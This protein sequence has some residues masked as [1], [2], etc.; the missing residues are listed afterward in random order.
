MPS[1]E[2][3]I[4]RDDIDAVIIGSPHTAHLPQT[5]AAAAAGKHV[6]VEKPMAVSV[7]ECDRM[8]EACRGGRRQARRQQGPALPDRAQAAKELID[9][10]VIGDVRMI[11]TRGSWTSYFLGDIVGDDGRIIVPAKPWALDPAEGSQ[12]LGWGAHANDIIRWYSGSEAV[13]RV[14]ALSDVRRPAGARPDRIRPC[15][16]WRTA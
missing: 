5:L 2:A 9:D 6:Y 11:Q 10:G 14:R 4:A 1:V 3:L 15:T 8:I 16:R 12:Y 13:A 7:A